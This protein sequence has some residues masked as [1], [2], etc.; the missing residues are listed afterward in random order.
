MAEYRSRVA[1]HQ[2]RVKWTFWIRKDGIGSHEVELFAG[3]SSP[4][5][6]QTHHAH[7][8]F[9]N[10]DAAEAAAAVEVPGLELTVQPCGM[11]LHWTCI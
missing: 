9:A 5:M 7:D 6:H 11:H 10:R 2:S 3:R 1:D 8:G 4:Q